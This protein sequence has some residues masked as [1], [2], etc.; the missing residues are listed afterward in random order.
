MLIIFTINF[1]EK[2]ASHSWWTSITKII[3]ETQGLTKYQVIRKEW[4]NNFFYAKQNSKCC[5]AETIVT[6]V[7]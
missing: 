4:N 3:N 7:I 1:N 5:S 2:L 6:H